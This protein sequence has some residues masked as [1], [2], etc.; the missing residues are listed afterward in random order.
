MKH[1]LSAVAVMAVSATAA[2]AADPAEGVWKSE[3][4][5]TGG[6]IHVQ[7]AGCGDNRLCGVIRKVVGNDNQTIVG[8]NII[9]NMGIDGG[10]KYSGGTIWAP[11]TDKT[12]KSRMT[13]SGNT[14]VV[15]GCVAGGLICRGQNW[16]RVN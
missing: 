7:I 8:K 4:G 6:Y 10:D 3:P 14:L 13:L 11:D 9:N 2:F 5:E 1:F 12:Y 16:T 15:K